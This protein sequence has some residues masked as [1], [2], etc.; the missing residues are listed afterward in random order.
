MKRLNVLFYFLSA[1]ITT[2][3]LLLFAALPLRLYHSVWKEYR[4]LAIPASA[5]IK[6]YLDEAERIG[7]QGIVSE[8]SI[9]NRFSFLE[10]GANKHVPFTDPHRYSRWFSDES[11]SFRYLYIPYTSFFRFITFYFSLYGKK[12][13]FYL[14][15]A[16]PYAPLKAFFAFILFFYCIICSRKKILFSAAAGSFLCYV[17]SVR[18]SLSLATAIL[19]IFTA[20]YWLEALDNKTTI[21]WKQLKERIQCNV[22]MIILPTVSLLS[23]LADGFIPFLFFLLAL[24][25]SAASLFSVHSFLQLRETYREQYRQHPSLKIFV[26]HPQSWSQFWNTRYAMTM[27]LLT[28]CLLLISILLTLLFSPHQLDG[29]IAALTVPQPILQRPTPFTDEGFFSAR[30]SQP[31]GRLPDLSNYIEDCWFTAALPYLNIHDPLQPLTP[32]AQIRFDSFYEDTAGKLHREEK[33]LY[34]FNTAFIIQTLRHERLAS[35]PL[36]QMLIAQGGFISAVYQPL[37][38]FTRGKWVSFFITVGTL[39]FPCVLIIM[40]KIR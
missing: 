4:I 18:S 35:L 40:T 2:G 37:K 27:T 10:I 23:A 21:P 19:S 9:Q 6:T 7:I 26:M 3:T 29:S 16:F 20:A 32:N 25:M 34:E 14:E 39:L 8:L 12:T 13:A 38:L 1:F 30:A 5:D 22:F 17:L 11:G 15:P 31:Q 33:M 36:E 28:C 24:L